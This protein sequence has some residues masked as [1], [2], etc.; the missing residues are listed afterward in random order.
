[1]KLC[2]CIAEKNAKTALAA[3]GRAKSQGAA[4]A[5]LRLDYLENPRE[6]EQIIRNS[7]VPIIATC[8][9]V[10]DGGMFRGNEEQR[11]GNLIDAI[12][13]GAQLVD[14]ESD[15][16]KKLRVAV[17]SC[18]RLR[19]C[20]VIMSRHFLSGVPDR[21]Y[22]RK[23]IEE[24][25]ECSDIAKFVYFAEKKHECRLAVEI[26]ARFA[27][28]GRVVCFA[29]GENGT[30]SRIFDAKA[31]APIAYCSTGQ[32]NKVAKGQL[33]VFQMDRAMK[34][35][36]PLV[37]LLGSPVS[38]SVSPQMQ[39]AAFDNAKIGLAYC[40]LE[41]SPQDLED[42]VSLLKKAAVA[43][44][45]ITIP[46]KERMVGLVDRL[47]KTAKK[48]GA[49][50]TVAIRNGILAGYNTDCIGAYEALGGK[51]AIQGKNVLVL[52]AGGGA[53]AVA[54]ACRSMG[55]AGNVVVA[56]RRMEQA[57]QIALDLGAEDRRGG[58]VSAAGF[59][60]PELE[61]A[62]RKAD[63]IVNCTPVGMSPNLDT[64]PIGPG[65]LEKRHVVFDIIFNPIETALV[66]AAARRG[67][68]IVT[69]EK[70]LVAQ[71]A[72]GFMIWT[73]K[74]P[75]KEKMAEAA[76]VALKHPAKKIQSALSKKPGKSIAL[77]GFMGTGKSSVGRL[78]SRML[79]ARHIDTDGEIE[80]AAGKSIPRIFKE[81]GEEK[82]REHEARAIASA[83]RE[84]NAVISCGGGA[85]LARQNVEALKNGCAVILLEAKPRTILER[86]GRARKRP[87]IA[88]E[89]PLEKIR[90]L[91][92]LR[93]NI[94]SN[95]AD[96]RIKTDGKSI[97]Q[98][99]GKIVKITEQ[100]GWC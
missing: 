62:C 63:I 50:N 5:E 25:L 1:V 89:K 93:S 66:K 43:G 36:T 46:H 18:A 85:V 67:C 16:D 31:G 69:G 28:T 21:D 80:K 23:F 48:I 88:G 77:I 35:R 96:I 74:I 13:S 2:A 100:E 79:G 8:R 73:G 81:D 58:K 17:C 76:L 92:A 61:D 9:R 94:Y 10:C 60:K 39:N 49:V 56:A 7:Q 70:M 19:K 64:A 82:F 24:S 65:L 99:A 26:A 86:I 4:L 87:L 11:T 3:I 41:T 71:G 33:T 37:V 95:A 83:A 34:S 29:A 47:D 30:A 78:V 59:S 68:R 98:V 44:F 84:R 51:N 14:V 40:L 57:R 75:D 27:K 20:T 52:G 45:N 22:A 55:K 91:L 38:H 12:N 42:T 32:K 6:A 15:M 97:G 54:F 53:R 72:A 90:K